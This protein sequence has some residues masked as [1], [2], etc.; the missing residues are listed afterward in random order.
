L[1]GQVG[2]YPPGQYPPGG[3]RNPGNNGPGL[4]LPGRSSKKT[5]EQKAAALPRT[6][7]GVL[8]TL[9]DK[10]LDLEATDTRFLSIEI[11]DKTAKPPKLKVG[12]SVD[13]EATQDKDGKFHAVSIKLNATIASTISTNTREEQ[14]APPDPAAEREPPPTTI[15]TGNGKLYDD[16]DSG[17]PKLKR[18]PPPK[19]PESKQ[20]GEVAE[21]RTEARLGARTEP[22]LT[23][24]PP[25]LPAQPNPR[26]EFIAKARAAATEFTAGLPNYFCQEMA[27]RYVSE[28]RPANW[29]VQDVISVALVYENG[30]ESYK[31]FTIN[32]KPTK[33]SPEESGA[34]SSGEFGT[35]LADLFSPGS[36][37]DFKYSRDTSINHVAASVYDF[38]VARERSGWKIH[39][40]GQFVLPAYRG[41]V[42]IDKQSF[43]VLRIEMQAKEIPE[44]FP[45]VSVETAL[46]YDYISLG[47]PEKF[48][49][50]V[51]SEVLSCQRGSNFCERNAIDFR[52]YHKYAGEST[53]KFN[54]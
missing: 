29:S 36:A 54:Q 7:S 43:H 50:P 31:D 42:W 22:P 3:N 5:E 25:E 49:L 4:P 12:D 9:T 27:T 52:N 37:A 32:G 45:L 17:P 1:L 14:A 34:W 38:K 46:D 2:Q 21:V 10:S 18:G 51:H 40:P 26:Q 47:T 19:H 44:E 39:V 33:K 16:G 28:S 11:D 24:P 41:S 13:V 15:V 20:T 48:L 35:I 23:A 30:K 53:I 6:Y 8:R